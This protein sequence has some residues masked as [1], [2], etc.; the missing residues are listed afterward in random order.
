MDS[1]ATLYLVLA[2]FAFATLLAPV[3]FWPIGWALVGVGFYLL[4][5]HDR[6]FW[7]EY[8]GKERPY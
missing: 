8:L 6:R 5:R 7:R 4:A 2:A 1:M 3:W